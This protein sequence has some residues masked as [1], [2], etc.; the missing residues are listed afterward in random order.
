MIG[1]HGR[2]EAVRVADRV[3][4][5]PERIADGRR[6]GGPAIAGWIAGY[7]YPAVFLA[8]AAV[9]VG[10][11]LYVV[12]SLKETKAAPHPDD[13]PGS[14]RDVLRDRVFVVWL[15]VMSLANFV[16]HQG[17]VALAAWM[18]SQGHAA[19]TFGTV[20]GLNG[21]LIVLV[22]PWIAP[23]L[24]RFDPPKVMALGAGLQGLGFAVH[25]LP[26][27]VPGHVL[28]VLIW[29]SGEIITNPVSSAVVSRLAPRTLRARY[30]GL[31][32]M[33]FS[34]AGLVG[35]L[36]G[37]AVLDRWGAALWAG[38]LVVGVGAGVA[39]LAIGPALRDRLHRADL[40]N[41]R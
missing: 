37:A 32:G 16:P 21:L 1:L 14:L 25:G 12:R 31:L 5:L 30:Q 24:T 20:L 41:A 13:A 18:K 35:P 38:C 6:G 3:R 11:A 7:S 29:T 8:A 19:S 26:L 36:V 2:R 34:F 27:G 15:A 28:A 33:S 22:Q 4:D 40:E 9:Q 23:A 10:W 17:F 39:M